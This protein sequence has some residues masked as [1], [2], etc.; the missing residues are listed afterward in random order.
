MSRIVMMGP[1]GVGKGTQAALLA[2]A[3]GV[4]AVSTGDLFREHVR[5]RTPLGLEVSG[6]LAA[7]EYVPDA[8]TNAM[9]ADR[10]AAPDAQNGFILDGY[11]RTLPQ[12]G[13]LDRMLGDLST[14]AG[15]NPGRTLPQLGELDRMLGDLSTTAGTN[16][17]RTLPQLGELDRMLG[18]ATPLD[19]VVLL[20]ADVEEI[21]ARIVL[22]AEQQ[23]RSD[24]TPEV[25][26]RRIEIYRAETEPL[27]DAYAERGLLLR[28]EGTGSLDEVTARIRAALDHDEAAA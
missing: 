12:L 28:V 13:E 3:L 20:Q 7:G 23:G 9:V 16:P 14:T 25:V 27:A 1:P 5:T 22:R 6:L 10:L 19:A 15:T 2:V 26:R 4:P 21:V 24:D 8:V 11:P 18:P 17:G